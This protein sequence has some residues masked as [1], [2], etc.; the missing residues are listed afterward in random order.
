[1]LVL[2]KLP[3]AQEKW[4]ARGRKVEFFLSPP[5]NNCLNEGIMF[6]VLVSQLL[7]QE[8]TYNLWTHVSIYIA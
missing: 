6:F 8:L 2:N 3:R 4:R 7:A 5:K 1:M